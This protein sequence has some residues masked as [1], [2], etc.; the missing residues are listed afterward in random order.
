VTAEDL[1][2]AAL[3][4]DLAAFGA[5]PEIRDLVETSTEVSRALGAWHLDA[6]TRA[7][8]YA[9]VI[10]EAVAP[11]M[12]A[13]LRALGFD[14]RVQAIA[15]GAVVTL[16]AAAAVGVAL[17]RGRRRAPAQASALGA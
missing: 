7:R 8:I 16:A 10:V 1:L 11:G 3:E 14:R 6:E 9:T 5:R 4:S 17:G 12:N 2:E 13:R 15:G